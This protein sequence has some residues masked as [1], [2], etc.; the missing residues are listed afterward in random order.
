MSQNLHIV[1]SE[2]NEH[3]LLFDNVF[4]IDEYLMTY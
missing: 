4:L 2:L 1:Y 3:V